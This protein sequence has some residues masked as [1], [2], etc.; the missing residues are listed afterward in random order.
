MADALHQR[1]AVTPTRSAIT[2][3]DDGTSDG[4]SDFAAI[5]G[6]T[7]AADIANLAATV[8]AYRLDQF[9]V[10]AANISFNS[11]KITNLADPTAAQDAATKAYVDAVAQGLDIKPSVR[12]ATTANGTLATAF[13]NGQTVDGVT[14]AT[15]NRILIK[16]Q[17]SGAENGIYTVN[18]SGAPTRA[19]D[20]DAWAEIPGG[21]CFVEEGT[22]NADTGWACTNNAGGTLGSTAITFTQFSGAGTYTAGTGLT[23]AG[24][25]FSVNTSVIAPLDS[26]TFTGTPAAPTASPGTNT[27]QLATTAFVTAALT[28]SGAPEPVIIIASPTTTY[29]ATGLTGR[30]VIKLAMGGNTAISAPTFTGLAANSVYK[31]W[32]ECTATSADRTPSFSGF[33]TAFGLDPARLI[34][35]GT[36]VVFETEA[37]TDGSGAVTLHRLIGEID[38]AAYP[39]KATPTGADSVII[40]DAAA[41]GVPKESTLASIAAIAGRTKKLIF[42]AGG[43]AATEIVL[44]Q[45]KGD[46]AIGTLVAVI[47]ETDTGSITA[48]IQIADHTSADSNF[49]ATGAA[50]VT[51]LNALSVSTTPTRTAASGANTMAKTGATDRILQI[52]QTSPSGSPNWVRYEF[53][54]TT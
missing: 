39:D 36:T 6:L 31:V 8:Q 45:N 22:T 40:R 38:I 42:Y 53:E 32:Y 30:R 26:P 13:A 52:V 10:P 43:A 24:V 49:A 5:L 20:F 35:S 21:F 3:V 2:R 23:L 25:Q 15:G 14:L 29:Q 41:S 7:V 47:A 1:P 44:R 16:N 33:T 46:D 9:A 12:A 48:N 27:T 18:A 17:S 19:T 11:Q 28:A 37:H 51:S 4:K 54:Y 34:P 50:S